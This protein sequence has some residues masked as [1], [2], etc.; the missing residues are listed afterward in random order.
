MQEP[1]LTISDEALAKVLEV[2]GREPDADQLALAINITGVTG[3]DFSYELSFINVEDAGDEDAVTHHGPLPVV[4]PARHVDKLRGADLHMD[5]GSLAINNPN[6]PVPE[7]KPGPAAAP[8]SLSERVAAILDERINPAIAAHG[9]WVELVDVDGDTVLLRLGG[10][11]QGCSL[12]RMTLRHGIETVLRQAIPE[13]GEIVDI[14]D[15][16][17]GE[18]PYY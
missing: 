6:R 14:T 12:A 5:D 15:H 2:R 1:I 17:S 13:I 7:I 9:G 3:L 10:G 8:G 16:T 4:V 11:C 18:S